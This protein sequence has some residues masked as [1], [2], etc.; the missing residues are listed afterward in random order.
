MKEKL[1]LQTGE[2]GVADNLIPGV[3]GQSWTLL[4]ESD[5]MWRIYSK[6]NNPKDGTKNYLDET[7]V[8]IK[9]TARKLFDAIYTSDEDMARAY[10]GKIIYLSQKDFNDYQNLRSPLSP[11]ALNETFV[12]SY[13][14][15]REAFAHEQ[16]V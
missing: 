10:I 13:F 6:I 4:E 2:S 15:K 3:F 5:A 7:S 11:I 16:E 1:V 14:L 9:T 12:N 8:R